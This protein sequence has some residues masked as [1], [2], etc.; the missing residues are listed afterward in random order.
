MSA[1]QYHRF[2][3]N[4]SA[5]AERLNRLTKRLTELTQAEMRTD[6]RQQIT[7][8]S[9]LQNTAQI[10]PNLTVD[11]SG[12]DDKVTQLADPNAL[13]ATLEILFENAIQ[14]GAS[15]ITATYTNATLF[16]ADDGRG[17]SA[18]NAEHVFDAFFTT[19]RENGGTGL[20]LTIAS[21]LLKQSRAKLTLQN[22]AGPTIFAIEFLSQ[23]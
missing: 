2:L 4:I 14:H 1:E 10:Y 11:H 21:A 17:V 16:I 6:Q 9:I 12:I 5:D 20:G 22:N 18:N 8:S 3:D 7:L 23:C 13:S 19:Q 15:T